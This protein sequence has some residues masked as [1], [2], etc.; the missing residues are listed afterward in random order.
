MLTKLALAYPAS[1]HLDQFPYYQNYIDLCRLECSALDAFL[2]S[3]PTQVA[4]IGSGSLPLSSICML[5][6]YTNLQV[7]NI[8]RDEPALR[9]SQDLC[10]RLGYSMTISCED[11]TVGQIPPLPERAASMSNWLSFDVVFLAALVGMNTASKLAILSS[12]ACK[13]RPGTIIVARSA[14]GL[15]SVL[16]PVRM[17]IESLL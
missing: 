15:R 16:Y 11:V 9:K 3:P 4:F 14:Q 12:L 7:H 6:H 17:G 8:D 5:N 13:L 2:V 1:K 10:G